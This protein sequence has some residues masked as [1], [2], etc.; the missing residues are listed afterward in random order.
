MVLAAL[1]LVAA[2]ASAEPR[3]D[4]AELYYRFANYDSSSGIR[5]PYGPGSYDIRFFERED[6]CCEGIDDCGDDDCGFLTDAALSDITLTFDLSDD[7]VAWDLSIFQGAEGWGPPTAEWE[8]FVSYSSPDPFRF[9]TR[10][11]Q[12][13]STIGCGNCERYIESEV[14]T[15]FDSAGSVWR[16]DVWLY[17]GA[18][19][20]FG[21]QT[22]SQ[23]YSARVAA[24]PEPATWAMMLLGVGAVGVPLRRRRSVRRPRASRLTG[25][26]E[27]PSRRE[28][29][30]THAE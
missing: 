16:G 23:V 15:Y 17:G 29:P 4:Y 6:H 8:L 27:L 1:A 5:A 7:G 20:G 12:S 24:V 9:I 25:A 30:V 2:P 10:D 22:L 3:L 11:A 26:G 13:L 28:R 18:S 19:V 21:M 14:F